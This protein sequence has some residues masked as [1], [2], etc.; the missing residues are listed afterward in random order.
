MLLAQGSGG[1]ER[2][3]TGAVGN[4]STS[5]G[6]TSGL[7]VLF[8]VVAGFVLFTALIPLSFFYFFFPD[9]FFLSLWFFVCWVCGALVLFG[10][11]D[12]GV[13]ASG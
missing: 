5:R 6:A 11:W 9:R 8:P 13:A 3:V 1:G 4:P 7:R 2:G 12:C 10:F